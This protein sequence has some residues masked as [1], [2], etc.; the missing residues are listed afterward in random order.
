[1][2]GF[3]CFENIKIDAIEKKPENISII[4]INF[5]TE[6]LRR[7]SFII[8]LCFEYG[9]SY[10]RSDIFP[11]KNP[12]RKSVGERLLLRLFYFFKSYRVCFTGASACCAADD[13]KVISVF[14]I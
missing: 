13:D 11:V 10:I 3:K 6:P 7:S 12:D 14:E 2:R 1:M 5:F 4:A 9:F 8:I